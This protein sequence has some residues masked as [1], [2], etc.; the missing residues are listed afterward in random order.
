MMCFMCDKEIG[1]MFNVVK[2]II[3]CVKECKV[4]GCV[5]GMW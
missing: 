4:I 5:W 2:E 3:K 1:G